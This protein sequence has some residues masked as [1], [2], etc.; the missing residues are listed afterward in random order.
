MG[1]LRLQKEQE[2]DSLREDIKLLHSENKKQ[3][4]AVLTMHT[5]A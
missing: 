2:N 1:E 5:F 3:V 4:D